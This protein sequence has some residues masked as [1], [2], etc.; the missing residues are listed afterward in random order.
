[1]VD[2]LV[3]KGVHVTGISRHD[4]P[5]LPS[6]RKPQ[7]SVFANLETADPATYLTSEYDAVFF[8]A[9]S[10]SVPYS[11]KDPIGDLDANTRSVVRILQHLRNLTV[12][13]RFIYASSAAVYGTSVYQPMDESHPRNPL[14]PYGVSKLV[15]EQYVSL[16]AH[17]FGVPGASVRPFSIYGPGQQKQ[18]VFDISRRLAAGETPLRMLGSPDVSRDFVHVEDAARAMWIVAQNAELRGETF[19]V[20]SGAETTLGELAESLRNVA[21]SVAE[22]EFSGE[23]REG[24]PLHW[25]GDISALA[26]LGY[27]PQISLLDG[28]T[29]TFEWTAGLAN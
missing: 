23:V 7:V 1:M 12:P 8:L 13:P 20:G 19:N 14:S 29:S 11:V 4:R 17:N 3:G 15:A 18:V 6:L 21:G 5:A 24:D 28:L 26:A 2:L 10:A 22:V 27:S 25:R 16:F 9:G